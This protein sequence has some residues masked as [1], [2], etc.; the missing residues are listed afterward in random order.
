MIGTPSVACFTEISIRLTLVQITW[1]VTHDG[2]P[3][4]AYYGAKTWAEKAAWDFM[5]EDQ[6]HFEL[7]T[8]CPPMVII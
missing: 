1:E 2:D 6:P 3:S 4:H 8:L 7:V 5:K